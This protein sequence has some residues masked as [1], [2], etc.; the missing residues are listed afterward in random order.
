M[1]FHFRYRKLINLSRINGILQANLY[2]NG[3]N[4]INI[5][6]Q[7]LNI[8]SLLGL[9][10]INVC[11]LAMLNVSLN[12]NTITHSITFFQWISQ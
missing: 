2:I 1:S 8:A 3:L 11:N 6:H 10:H 9:L 4:S 12:L 5:K 7:R